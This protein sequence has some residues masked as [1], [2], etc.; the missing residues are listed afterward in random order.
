ML[1]LQSGEC[2]KQWANGWFRGSKEHSTI[3]A[4]WTRLIFIFICLEVVFNHSWLASFC[5]Q[6][7]KVGIFR[8][9]L[10]LLKIFKNGKINFSWKESTSLHWLQRKIWLYVWFLDNWSKMAPSLCVH[11]V[12]VC[13]TL[14]LVHLHLPHWVTQLTLG[15]VVVENKI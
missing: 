6:R 12:T 14:R 1:E 11:G 2:D 7:K 8:R 15:S 5:G 4:L 3:I 9:W 10:I 13:V